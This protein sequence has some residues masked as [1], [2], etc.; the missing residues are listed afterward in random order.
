MLMDVM[1]FTAAVF[2]MFFSFPALLLP[3]PYFEIYF[4]VN[5]PV[6][7]YPYSTQYNS[8]LTVC[9]YLP[10]VLNKVLKWSYTQ[11]EFGPIRLKWGVCFIN[12]LSKI[13]MPASSIYLMCTYPLKQDLWLSAAACLIL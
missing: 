6:Y 2:S 9:T 5:H 8:S 7:T 10:T 13:C 1:H 3:V 12:S 4:V 11:S